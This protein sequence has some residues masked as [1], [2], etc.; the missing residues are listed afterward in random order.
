MAVSQLHRLLRANAPHA[1]LLRAQLAELGAA[2]CCEGKRAQL[3]G[4]R[5]SALHEG[6][7]AAVDE[8]VFGEVAVI[9]RSVAAQLHPP[10]ISLQPDVAPS[11]SADSAGGADAGWALSASSRSAE[12]TTPLRSEHGAWVGHPPPAFNLAHAAP[13]AAVDEAADTADSAE[14]ADFAEAADSA[15]PPGAA[16]GAA[17]SP[18]AGAS[19]TPLARVASGRLARAIA[20]VNAVADFT[21]Q[22]RRMRRRA[23]Q[24]SCRYSG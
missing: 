3:I 14:A 1:K 21:E 7:R 5:L 15:K 24:L 9:V 8:H 18:G 19:V 17:S 22:Q 2:L 13:T 16:P 6:V 23:A 20:R 11:P 4:E 12:A 10:P